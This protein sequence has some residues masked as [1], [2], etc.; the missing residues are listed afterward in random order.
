MRYENWPGIFEAQIK[1]ATDR[2]FAWGEFDCCLWACDVIEAMT[3]RDPA[4]TFRDK[5]KS[6]RGAYGQLKRQ[7]GGG[8]AEA[9]VAIYERMGFQ[10]IHK[11]FA[12]RGDV[13]LVE[14]PDGDALAIWTG[15]YCVLPSAL[16]PGLA[17]LGIG[18]VLKAWRVQ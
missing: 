14:T 2:I 4:E 11:N 10:E 3:G 13:V 5:Y 7:H 15:A 16:V 8:V 18:D 17:R 1:D 12:Q 9:A 6:K